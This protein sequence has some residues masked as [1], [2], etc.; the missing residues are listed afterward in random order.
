MAEGGIEKIAQSIANKRLTRRDV[1]KGTAAIALQAALATTIGD[2]AHEQLTSSSKKPSSVPAEQQTQPE[3]PPDILSEEELE[4][5]NIKIYPTDN[6]SLHLRPGVFQFPLFND[7]REGKIKKVVITL[8][9]SR[10]VGDDTAIDNL[11]EE[12]RMALRGAYTRLAPLY[13]A[14]GTI[15]DSQTIRRR[16]IEN[17]ASPQAAER[18]Q[19]I[20]DKH[21]E[22]LDNRQYIYLAVGKED[23]PEPSQSY[24]KPS[25]FP[26]LTRGRIISE[27]DKRKSGIFAPYRYGNK[28]PGFLLRHEIS[29]YN[30]ENTHKGEWYTD[31]DAY[32]SIAKAWE[33]FRAKKESTGYPFIFVTEKGITITK[34]QQVANPETV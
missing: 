18:G 3:L 8:V 17:P 9:D 22:I 29:H 14:Q 30:S 26:E 7:A 11:A 4:A 2:I 10:S 13:P 20:T 28:T 5:A 23:A 34:N 27:E 16:S 12:P 21:P 24:P 32:E 6:V 1:I 25:N 15:F 19:E 31:T 33:Q